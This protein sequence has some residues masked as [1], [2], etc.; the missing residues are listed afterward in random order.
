MVCCWVTATTLTGIAS[1]YNTVRLG[2]QFWNFGRTYTQALEEILCIGIDLQDS[3]LRVLVVEGRDFGDV[4]ILALSLLFLELERDTAD[5]TTLDT[6][7]Q[8]GGETSNLVTKTLG[9]DDGNLG[10]DLLVGLEVQG[11]TRVVL[12][13]EDL[14]GTLDSL[15]TNTTLYN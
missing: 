7:H 13:D 3:A 6:L 2:L 1:N 11:K 4:L 9:G 5:R 10:G 12:L 15:G 8:M 14:G